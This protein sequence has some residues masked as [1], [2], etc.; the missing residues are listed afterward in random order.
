MPP[1]RQTA[2]HGARGEDLALVA[3]ISSAPRRNWTLLLRL[4]AWLR[5][6]DACLLNVEASFLGSGL[7]S[8]KKKLVAPRKQTPERRPQAC[9]TENIVPNLARMSSRWQESRALGAPKA[10]AGRQEP[11]GVRKAALGS[12]NEACGFKNEACGSKNE[13][14]GF[15]S[16]LATSATRAF[17]P[18]FHLGRPQSARSCGWMMRGMLPVSCAATTRNAAGCWRSLP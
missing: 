1:P 14:C 10:P 18:D 16:E 13:A 5:R 15:N 3:A 6:A 11:C 9:S 4:Q 8:H 17:G 7:H 12:K 2:Y